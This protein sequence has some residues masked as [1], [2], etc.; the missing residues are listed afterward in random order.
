MS[1]D[2]YTRL[3]HAALG[4]E[5]GA[6]STPPIELASVRLL[7]GDPAGA[8][9]SYLRLGN[10]TWEALERA[11]GVLED[12]DATVFASG[13]AASFATM[14][15]LAATHPHLIVPSD[16]YYGTR[17]VGGM[18]GPFGVRT[19]ALDLSDAAAVRSALAHGPAV[20]WAES[21]S[22]PWLRVV[23]LQALADL[24]HAAGGYFVVDN[25]TATAATQRPLDLGA[26]V[27]VTSLT[28]STSGH[29]D[30]VLG[31]VATRSAAVRDGLRLW[32]AQ[33]GSIAGPFEAWL[34]LRGVL[35]LPLRIE[36]Q[37][38]HADALAA[39]LAAHPRVRRVHHP[40]QLTGEALALARRQQPTGFGPILSFEVDGDAAATD[41]ILAAAT[42]IRNATSFGGVESTWERRAR[43]P[44]EDAPASLIRLSVGLEALADLTADLASALA[45]A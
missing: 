19:T 35:T 20:V 30:V 17:K 25:T 8:P 36:R 14:L 42:L 37:S 45:V 13:Q 9:P 5:E 32:R 31:S 2:A 44:A 24:A 1:H 38:R 29:A 4:R 16:G 28:K 33:A 22:N 26:D 39:W 15:T 40:S 11:L 21:P 18:L 27:S 7:T 23:D 12:A 6:P 41:R 34:A 10:P 43:W 3:L